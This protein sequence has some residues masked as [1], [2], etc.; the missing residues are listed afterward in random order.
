MQVMTRALGCIATASVNADDLDPA[1]D[2]CTAENIAH[3]QY[4]CHE[5]FSRKCSAMQTPCPGTLSCNVQ[6]A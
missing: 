3:I 2:Q 4:G 5:I 1:Q 6:E